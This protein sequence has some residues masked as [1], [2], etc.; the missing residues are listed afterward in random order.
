[1]KLFPRAKSFNEV[2]GYYENLRDDEWYVE[3][4][5]LNGDIE[6]SN[7]TT[8]HFKRIKQGDIVSMNNGTI[9]LKIAIGLR[10]DLV[11]ILN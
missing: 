8:G 7:G 11:N 6:I 10:G 4:L 9:Y 5:F 1:M 3:H 2:L